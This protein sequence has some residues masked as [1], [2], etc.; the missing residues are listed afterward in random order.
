MKDSA[1]KK[2]SISLAALLALVTASLA[3]RGGVDSSDVTVHG[4]KHLQLQDVLENA[5]P[6]RDYRA[7]AHAERRIDPKQP[8]VTHFENSS[9]ENDH[10]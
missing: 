8:G 1:L 4:R 7:R 9:V 6:C 3:A 2:L 10:C 5:E